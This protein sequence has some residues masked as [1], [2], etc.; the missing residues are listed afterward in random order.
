MK[1][2]HSLL[3]L[4]LLAGSAWGGTATEETTISWGRERLVASEQKADSLKFEQYYFK[5]LFGKP[6]MISLIRGKSPVRYGIGVCKNGKRETVS[7]MARKHNAAAAVNAG[8]F[9]FDPA[10][11]PVGVLK[12]AN[13]V[14]NDSIDGLKN[15]GYLA[16]SPEQE[17]K[18]LTPAELKLEGS[19]GGRDV[20]LLRHLQSRDRLRNAARRSRL[21]LLLHF[22]HRIRGRSGCRRSFLLLYAPAAEAAESVEAPPPG[23]AGTGRFS[24]F[25]HYRS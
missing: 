16:I 12:S 7:S 10:S 2:L 19:D 3:F 25:F 13:V 9:T 22:P 1:I 8:F 15:R 23:P 24:R 20:D 4:L 6:L 17:V 14:Y 18:I 21:H 5:E 11:R